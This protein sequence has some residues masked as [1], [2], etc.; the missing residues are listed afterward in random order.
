MIDHETG[1][2]LTR[3][4]L[5]RSA[6]LGLIAAGLASCVVAPP[7]RRAVVTVAPPPP[8]YEAPP[9]PPGERMVWDPGRW[10][11][12]GREYRWVPGHY[13]E[14]PDREARWVPGR[15]VARDGGWVWEEGHWVR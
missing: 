9:P 13:V 10:Q 8:R 3:R 4:A 15:W 7:P 5:F 2:R 12:D 11:W 1:A 14:R 6:G